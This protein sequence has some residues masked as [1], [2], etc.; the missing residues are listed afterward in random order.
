MTAALFLLAIH[1][2]VSSSAAIASSIGRAA[3]DSVIGN[4]NAHCTRMG[5]DIG[6]SEMFHRLCLEVYTTE[7]KSTSDSCQLHAQLA[8]ASCGKR[9]SSDVVCSLFAL[10]ML[11]QCQSQKRTVA[12]YGKQDSHNSKWDSDHGKTENSNE[13]TDSA[14]C[15]ELGGELFHYC[16]YDSKL[17]KKMCNELASDVRAACLHLLP[18]VSK[19]ATCQEKVE[20]MEQACKEK[21]HEENERFCA[22]VGAQTYETLCQNDE[23]VK[24]VI[25]KIRNSDHETIHQK[26]MKLFPSCKELSQKV[27]AECKN[28]G[29]FNCKER[30]SNVLDKCEN[31]DGTIICKMWL[32]DVEQRCVEYIK[33]KYGERSKKSEEASEICTSFSMQLYNDVCMGDDLPFNKESAAALYVLRKLQVLQRIIDKF[34]ED[35][36]NDVPPQSDDDVPADNDDSGDNVPADSDDTDKAPADSDIDDDCVD[37]PNWDNYFRYTCSDY[38][39]KGWCA[40]GAVVSGEEWTTGVQFNEPELSCCACGGGTK[41]NSGDDDNNDDGEEVPTKSDENGCVDTPDWHNF[42]GYTCSYY[43]AKEWCAN[44]AVVSGEEWSTGKDFNYPELSCC[45]CGRGTEEYNGND[46]KNSKT[47]SSDKVPADSDIYDGC[48][49]TPDWNNFFGYTCSDYVAKEWCANGAVVSGEEWTTGKGFNYPELSCCACGAGTGE[50]NGND[51]KN[52]KTDSSDKVPAD[53]DSNGCV[54]MPDWN[55]FF[56]YTCSDYVAKEW[57]AN[58]AVVSGEEWSTGKGFNY[59]ELSCCACGAGTG[60]YNGNDDKNSKTDSSDKVP[61]DS[62]IYDGCV[63]TPDWHNFFGY[64]CSD[65]TKAGWCANGAVVSGEEWALGKVFNYPELS[66]CACGA[67][68]GGSNS[69]KN[70]IKDSSDKVPADSDE[71]GGQVPTKSDENS[72]ADSS[73]NVPSGSGDNVPADSVSNGCVDTASWDNF[74][75]YTCSDYVTEGWNRQQR[76]RGVTRCPQTAMTTWA[77]ME[78]AGDESR[79]PTD[80]ELNAGIASRQPTDSELNA[81]I[82]SH[83]FLQLAIHSFTVRGFQ[84]VAK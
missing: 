58:G 17:S 51:D 69:D 65:Y 57:C 9:S 41:G 39:A 34:P 78:W 76:L 80:S 60:E 71:N 82:A 42:Y 63:D 81:E 68:T 38:V 31:H 40:N 26:I 6:D 50:Y 62:D 22:F 53:S 20:Y 55:N 59:P 79:Q 84:G 14:R 72:A 74:F 2:L 36:S 32:V 66:C 1:V 73:D 15:D 13:E 23:P 35:D 46:D 64:T 19:G 77:T 37:A 45:A 5:H 67:G 28:Q 10:E 16:F 33:E 70:S 3:C 18:E 44:G 43:V 4:L 11:E 8:A 12:L 24:S 7:R 25:E 83:L 27:F 48:V 56:G 30:S 61:A 75:S 54:D 47:D 21:A 29:G 52:S 49:D